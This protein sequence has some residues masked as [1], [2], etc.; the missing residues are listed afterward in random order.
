[1][2]FWRWASRRSITRRPKV[3]RGDGAAGLLDD[4]QAD[5]GEEVE[6]CW[7]WRGVS[8]QALGRRGGGRRYFQIRRMGDALVMKRKPC[9]RPRVMAEREF[10]QSL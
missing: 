5:V 10:G 6:E 2:G 1:M 3:S 4:A 9:T 7:C 8:S